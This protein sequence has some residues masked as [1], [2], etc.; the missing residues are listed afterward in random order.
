MGVN[1]TGSLIV[2][3]PPKRH[4]KILLKLPAN[5]QYHNGEPEASADGLTG[6]NDDPAN[7]LRI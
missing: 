5:T 3:G 7:R 6:R 2:F 1:D 4:D